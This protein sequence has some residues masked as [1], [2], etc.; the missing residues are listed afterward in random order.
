MSTHRRA[1]KQRAGVVVALVFGALLAVP[2]TPAFATGVNVSPGSTTVN[3]GSDTTVSVTVTPDSDQ[4][5]NGDISLSGLPAGVSCS[6]G[7]GSF[8]FTPPGAPKVVLLTLRA[9]D[10]APDANG[11]SVTVRVQ[12]VQ[13]PGI[14]NFTLTVKGKA[15]PSPEQPQTVKSVSGKVVI[16]AN[17]DPVENALVM[18]RDSRGKQRQTNTDSSGN[19]RFTGSTS[20]PIAPG[21]IDLGATKGGADPGTKSIDASAGQSVTGVRISVPIKV[22]ASPSPSASASEE[23]LPSDEATDEATDE[24]ASEQPAAQQPAANE[25]SGGFGSWLLILLGGLFVAVGVGTI[26]LLY[27]R[28]KNE[29][30]DGDGDGPHGPTG[31]GGP[32]GAAGAV[33]GARGAYRGADDQTRV[34]NGMGAGAAPTMVGGTSLSDAPTMMHRPVVDDVP[35][36]PYGAPPGPGYGAGAGAGQAGWAG[37]GYGDGAPGQGGYG[38]G[39]NGYGAAP[40]SGGGY[41]TAPSSGGGYGSRDYGAG[42]AGYP[43]AP[44]GGYGG[45]R[46]DEPT[47]RYTGDSTQY[48][49][50]ADP[51]PTSTYQPDQGRGYDQPGQGQYGR[52]PEQGGND[53]G[54]GGGYGAPAGGYDNAPAG[55]YGGG[56]QGG[57]DRAP[58]GGYD[59][60]QTGAYDGGQTGGYDGRQ[61][62]YEGGQ[63]GGYDGYDK[64]GGYGGGDGYGQ[65]PQGGYGQPGGYGQEQPPQQRGGGYDNQGYDQGGYYADPAEAGRGRP[66]AQDRGGRRLDWLDD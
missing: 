39:D 45:E 58:A 2:A 33:P 18:L 54:S 13:N 5:K 28:R 55:G 63:Q 10:S 31:P 47:G 65:S 44:G 21:R 7:C 4:E 52:G 27:M 11:A 62:G 43:P 34:V 36:D 53:Y 19:F 26:V 12:G 9:N 60:G 48:A 51:Y 57:Y 24:P 64:R 35:P 30:G 20:D 49:P 59:G 41:G 46:Y 15:A 14:G 6:S 29:D 56:Q 25:D 17:G 23:A 32:A 50:P 38:G 61:A 22:E 37:N 66:D 42:A 40:S 16:A 3:A 1:W 8:N